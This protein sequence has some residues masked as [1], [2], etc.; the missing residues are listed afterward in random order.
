[1]TPCKSARAAQRSSGNQK[2]RAI[3]ESVYKKRCSVLSHSVAVAL[4]IFV[5]AGTMGTPEGFVRFGANPEITRFRRSI[6]R[7]RYPSAIG[8]KPMELPLPTSQV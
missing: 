2:G 7:A 3:E 4:L 8:G 1:M 5:P 6:S